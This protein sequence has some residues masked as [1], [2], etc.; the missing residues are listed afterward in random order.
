MPF[1]TC[2][3][4]GQAWSDREA[5]LRD[6]RT[7][8]VGYQPHF[9]ELQAGLF[10]FNHACGTTLALPAG[11]FEDLYQGR[12]FES[13]LAGS[14]ACAGH[15]L[16]SKDLQPCPA[17]CA[18]AFVRAILDRVACWPKTPPLPVH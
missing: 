13:R 14:A 10:L 8:L 12:I 2:P 7:C 18:C 17:A 6:P 5:F 9:A 3:S 11:L 16:N 15:C 4:C 1:K